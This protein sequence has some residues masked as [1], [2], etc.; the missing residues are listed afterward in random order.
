MATGNESREFTRGAS[1]RFMRFQDL[2]SFRVREILLVSSR[3]DSFILSEDGSLYASLLDEYIGLGLTHIPGIT[4]VSTGAEALRRATEPNRFD[5]ILCSLRLSDMH[6]S[7][8]ARRIK[9]VGVETPVVLL[10]YDNRELNELVQTDSVTMFDK[11]FVWQG[12]FRIF[13]AVIK[14]VEDRANIAR[15]TELVGVQSI[16]VVEDNVKFYSSYL[17]LIY[18]AVLEHTAELIAEGVNP[19]HKLLRMRAR[20]KIILCSTYEEAWHYFETYHE[21]VLG[22]ISDIEFPRGGESDPEAGFRLARAVRRSH[23]DIPV[24][25]QSDDVG[26]KE[27]AEEIG[28]SFLQKDSAVLLHEL[29]RYMEHHF[30]FGEF[31]FRVE[32]GTVKGRATDLRTLEEQLA[33]VP[34]ES[35]AYHGARN[36]F[37]TW[38]KA[39]T[40]FLLA[41]RLRPEKLSDYA[42]IED[43]RAHLIRSLREHRR[44]QQRGS[45]V[46][47]DPDTF[48]Q[49]T[50]FA[51][52]GGGSLGGKARGLGFANSLIS[53]YGLERAFPDVRLSV[54]P[55][56]II[57]TEVFD[58]FLENNDLWNLAIKSDDDEAILQRFLDAHFPDLVTEALAAFLDTV[59]IPLSVRSSSLLEDSQFMP[60]AGVYDTFM[61]ANNQSD[62]RVRLDVL[63]DTVKRVYASTFSRAAKTYIKSTPYRVEEEK[64]AV[65][66]QKLVGSVHGD[67]FYPDFSGVARSHNFYP[68]S[69]MKAE[70]GIASAAL[71]LGKQVVEGGATFR[72][73]PAY[74]RHLVQFAS[75]EDT[76]KYSQKDFFALTM[77]DPSATPPS[78]HSPEL[79]VHGL[80][81][82][83]RDAVLYAIGS[84]YSIQNHRLYDGVSRAGPRVVNFAP[85]LKN[86][87]FPLP[88]VLKRLLALG[89]EGMSGPVEIEFAVT[90]TRQPGEPRQFY[91]LQMRPMVIDQELERLS[92]IETHR[93]DLICESVDVLGSGVV[94]DIHDIVVVDRDRYNRA[95]SVT[96]ARAVGAINL[97]LLDQ[98]IPYVLIGVG[99]WGSADPWLGIPVRWEDISG[100]RVIVEAGMKDLKVTPSQGTHFFQNITATRT[101]YITVSSDSRKSF[102]DWEW[103]A[104]QPAVREGSCVRHLRLEKPLSVVMDGHRSHAIIVKPGRNLTS[105]VGDE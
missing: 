44:E 99:R 25:L 91:L 93:E 4:R 50:S 102:I 19:S 1:D 18:T 30:G 100:A 68:V 62:P 103:L 40:E 5:L 16:I 92:I 67:R 28:A 80:D 95:E 94:T 82:A 11:V 48:D 105:R 43:V 42:D 34:P 27:R 98:R 65:I 29:R 47:F 36:H 46:D 35:I 3:Y 66:V 79:A 24:L 74:P 77:P 2:M 7:D 101:G 81:V 10:T 64:M 6:A 78:D 51:R 23:S 87:L 54:P 31:V 15:D 72:F 58:Q 53:T 9:Q 20:P 71:G 37:S 32:D 57:G 97:E 69:P 52:V 49:G 26:N 22:V 83:E 38:L 89:K 21:H 104:S 76:L 56:I 13:L 41:Y 17:P 90:M 8:L 84:T 33:L 39:R 70:D 55:S 61:I 12:D 96:V 63:I 59:R 60:F 73:C 45:I 75:I 88:Q 14:F 86:D 85:I